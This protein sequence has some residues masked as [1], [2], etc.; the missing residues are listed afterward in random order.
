MTKWKKERKK[1]DVNAVIWRI[2]DAVTLLYPAITAN[3][4]K[5][6]KFIISFI[7]VIAFNTCLHKCKIEISMTPRCF[8]KYKIRRKGQF[9]FFL[10]WSRKHFL[11]SSC[12]L[13]KFYSIIM[14]VIW[15]R[16]IFFFSNF[17]TAKL[18]ST[19]TKISNNEAISAIIA[20][21]WR[22]LNKT[23][24]TRSETQCHAVHFVFNFL[25]YCFV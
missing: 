8:C 2:S 6:K 11:S 5:K 14:I 7:D 18:K 1:F 10:F 16:K 24:Y 3:K 20:I 17:L 21:K 13:A 23:P 19:W 4:I 15:N 9:V 22:M 25:F 12:A